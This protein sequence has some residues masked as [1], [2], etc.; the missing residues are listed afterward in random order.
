MRQGVLELREF[1]A[2]ALGG[3]ARVLVARKVT[4]A[5]ESGPGLDVLARGYATPFVGGIE[6]GVRRVVAAMPA[7]QG[8]EAW[9]AGERNCAT[10]VDETALPFQPALF[11]RVLAVHALE[12]AE[13]PRALLRE[14]CRVLA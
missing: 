2:S 12:E 8:V 11:D 1:Y 4:E 13:S 3:A 7:A 9:P 6:A 14:V 10:L 5:W